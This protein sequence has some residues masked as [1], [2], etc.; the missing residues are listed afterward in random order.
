MTSVDLCA[1]YKPWEVQQNVV[2]TIMDE[3]WEEVRLFDLSLL[4]VHTEARHMHAR[5][6]ERGRDQ[7]ASSFEPILT[8]V[9]TQG[10]E[11]K[12]QGIQPQSLMD[13]SL[14]HE[15]PKNQVNDP[16]CHISTVNQSMSH[17]ISGELH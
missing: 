3:F 7:H 2:S 15:L 12:R 5:T 14:A 11:E 10:D 4:L 9:F 1:M 17:L 8:F 6:R 13:R 16:R